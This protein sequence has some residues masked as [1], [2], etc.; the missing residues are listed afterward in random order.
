[1]LSRIMLFYDDSPVQHYLW[2]L[3]VAN[4]LFQNEIMAYFVC[5]C[6]V[7]F[8]SVTGVWNIEWWDNWWI[9]NDLEGNDHGLIE[10]LS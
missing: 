7:H 2:C 4:D 5:V 6:V 1:M 10:E 9:E 8:M 3:E